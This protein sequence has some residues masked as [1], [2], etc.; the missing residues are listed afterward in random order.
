MVKKTVILSQ[1][2]ID[3]VKELAKSMRGKGARFGDFSKALRKIIEDYK[4]GKI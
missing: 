2:N 1:A 4:N 3:F